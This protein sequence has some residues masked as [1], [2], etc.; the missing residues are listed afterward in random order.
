MTINIRLVLKVAAALAFV[1]MGYV[2]RGHSGSEEHI[3]W[4]VAGWALTAYVVVRIALA[5]RRGRAALKAQGGERVSIR[6]IEKATVSAMPVWMQGWSRTEMKFY[7][8]FWRA[9]R[10]VPMERDQRFSVSRGARS[11][12][13]SALAALA[14]A[15]LATVGL[16]LLTGW[17]TSLKSLLIGIACTAGPA[18]YLLVMLA[19][20]RRLLKETGHAVTGDGLALALGVR[21]TADI[22][23]ADLVSCVPISA[24]DAV[25][26]ETCVVSP[27]ERPNVLLTLQSGAVVAAE[28]FGYAF[29][30]GT[31]MLALYVDEPARFAGAVSAAMA[32][33]L[34]KYA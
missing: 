14:V 9:L 31:P 20:E 17:S 32:R 28:R 6:S 30:P 12:R 10:G 24:A 22:A 18:L 25:P 21:F 27:F 8:G 1:G 4:T 23:L 11:G 16:V 19:G 26:G 7:G 34:P 15:S 13:A 29:K 5:V 2:I 3:G 33:Q